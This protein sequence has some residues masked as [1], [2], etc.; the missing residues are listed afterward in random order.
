MAQ[1]TTDRTIAEAL[2]PSKSAVE[3]LGNAIVAVLALTAEPQPHRRVAA[4]LTF[5]RDGHR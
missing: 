3:K 5:L 2:A 4:V 1:G